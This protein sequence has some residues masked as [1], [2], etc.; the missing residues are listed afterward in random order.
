MSISLHPTDTISKLS[1][2]WKLLKSMVNRW[3]TPKASTPLRVLQLYILM[4]MR[5]TMMMICHTFQTSIMIFQALVLHFLSVVSH[6]PKIIT[7]SSMVT[8][9]HSHHLSVGYLGILH[10]VL[11]Q[12]GAMQVPLNDF[13]ARF[14]APHHSSPP[15]KPWISRCYFSFSLFLELLETYFMYI[16]SSIPW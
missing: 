4:K 10:Q 14:D 1:S 8:S 9:T 12:Q 16:I 15:P 3:P 5:M 11:A 7:I 2:A 6:L 13:Y